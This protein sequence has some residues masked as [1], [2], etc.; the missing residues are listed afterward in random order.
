MLLKRTFL[1]SAVKR[2]N[3]LTD[4]T[5]SSLVAGGTGTEVGLAIGGSNASTSIQTRVPTAR[6]NDCKIQQTYTCIKLPGINLNILIKMKIS[7][8]TVKTSYFFLSPSP[9][10]IRIPSASC[11]LFRLCKTETVPRDRGLG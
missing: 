6:I 11:S 2:W 1:N 10:Y 9:W 7:A 3:F 5:T 8:V 4:F